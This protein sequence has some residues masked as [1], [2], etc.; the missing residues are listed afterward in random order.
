MHNQS[1]LV[2]KFL[3]PLRLIGS[4]PLSSLALTLQVL[5]GIHRCCPPCNSLVPLHSPLLRPP[6]RCWMASKF[7]LSLQQVLPILQL[8][9]GTNKHFYKVG[10]LVWAGCS[11]K[12]KIMVGREYE[13][14]VLCLI[15]RGQLGTWS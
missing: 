15:F 9:G 12:D 5:E 11:G 7:P 3:V 13:L 4:S 2:L 6:C 10:T 1:K 14:C 8:I